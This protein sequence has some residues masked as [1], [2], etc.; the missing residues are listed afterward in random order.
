MDHFFPWA[1]YPNDGFAKLVV[2]RSSCNLAKSDHVV[3]FDH[4]QHWQERNADKTALISIDEMAIQS[5]WE[6]RLTESLNITQ[7]I[8]GRVED[9][10]E[11]WR[12]SHEV[13]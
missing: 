5:K 2:A 6:V 4:Y 12:S 11:L 3:V 13:C 7:I 8:Y 1:R 9:C 10:I